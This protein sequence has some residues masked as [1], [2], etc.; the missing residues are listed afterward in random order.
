MKF[1][2]K[3]GALY[4]LLSLLRYFHYTPYPAGHFNHWYY[5]DLE[6]ILFFF[7]TF[8]ALLGNIGGLY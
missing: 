1:K 8:Y 6:S 7:L 5:N 4:F 2:Q 3:N